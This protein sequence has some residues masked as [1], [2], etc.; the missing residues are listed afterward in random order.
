VFK[1]PLFLMV[2]I[3]IESSIPMDGGSGNITFLTELDP[4]I[5]N[6]LHIPLY[7]TLSFLWMR[8]L[9]ISGLTPVKALWT[10]LLITFFFGCLDEVHQSFIPGR[11][12]GLID[13]YLNSIGGLIGV[14][15][16]R[17]Y[18]KYE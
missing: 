16:Y 11:F 10:A 1:Y 7:G 6:L 15:V 3:F 5:Q 9:V 4:N 13:I 17:Y 12:G 2:L 14:F 18:G 8:A